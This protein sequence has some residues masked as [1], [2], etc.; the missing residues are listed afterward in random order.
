[1][2]R[3]RRDCVVVGIGV[4]ISVARSAVAAAQVRQAGQAVRPCDLFRRSRS[5]PSTHHLLGRDRRGGPNGHG[6]IDSRPG[7][8]NLSDDVSRLRR[9]RVCCILSLPQKQRLGPRVRQRALHTF[10]RAA[11]GRPFFWPERAEQ[12]ARARGRSLYAGNFDR[13]VG[14]LKAPG[15]RPQDLVV[16]GGQP[17]G[18]AHAKLLGRPPASQPQQRLI[19]I[20]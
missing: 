6:P 13:C 9:P 15:V 10:P 20:F 5:D 1:M 8:F 7:S 17:V 16:V 3:R 14:H 12:L 2:W 4:H 18:I 11:L 19:R